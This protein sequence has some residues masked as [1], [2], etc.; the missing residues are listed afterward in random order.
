M[1]SFSIPRGPGT[2]ELL[3]VGLTVGVGSELGSQLAVS[4]ALGFAASGT[5][6]AVPVAASVDAA[7]PQTGSVVASLRHAVAVPAASEP[8]P[9]G[10]NLSGPVVTGSWQR[11]GPVGP[12]GW[13]AE[14][15]SS[16]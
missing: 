15:P 5:S 7:E 9:V 10:C 8:G 1:L 13:P 2:S 6:A 12:V 4:V 3:A 11:L 14:Y 16:N